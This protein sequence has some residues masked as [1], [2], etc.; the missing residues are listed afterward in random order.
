MRPQE[1]PPLVHLL[2]TQF[3]PVGLATP[4]AIFCIAFEPLDGLARGPSVLRGY[5]CLCEH[6]T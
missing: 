3:S 6:A 4:N 5:F 1:I 2:Q